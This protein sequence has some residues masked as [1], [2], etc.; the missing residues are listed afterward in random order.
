MPNQNH[1]VDT[2]FSAREFEIEYDDFNYHAAINENLEKFDQHLYS[3]VAS[4]VECK[5]IANIKRSHK[6]ECPQCIEVFSEN[7]LAS[8]DFV[9][10]KHLS[11]GLK[12]PCLS[13]VHIIIAANKIFSILKGLKNHD[14]TE[15]MHHRTLKTIMS[16]LPKEDLYEQTNF[17]SHEKSHSQ[18]TH[19]EKF[20]YEIILEYMKQKSCKIGNRITEEEK[21]KY[22]RHTNKKLVHISG[23]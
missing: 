20:I 8:D 13:T 23:Q 12:I 1:I 16:L 9:T 18:W 3:Y 2:V 6:K 4:N 10:K 21:G 22:I 17:E 5:I 7:E 19:K 15:K 11:N 14:C